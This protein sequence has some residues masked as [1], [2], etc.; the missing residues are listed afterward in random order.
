[1]KKI[2]IFL[3]LSFLVILCACEQA[4]PS[5]TPAEPS[6]R[7]VPQLS[8]FEEGKVHFELGIANESA[9]DQPVIKDTN[10]RAVVTDEAGKIRNQMTIIDRPAVP[11]NETVFPLT[12]E[13][14]YDPGRYVLSLTGETIPSLSFSF[15][16]REVDDL[17]KLAAPYDYIN[18]HTEFTITDPDFGTN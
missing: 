2:K 7:F 17:R 6:L 3:I 11:G 16:I 14:V 4:S 18:P 1:M 5:P 15:E 9:Q 13:A 10:I 8:M 12:Y